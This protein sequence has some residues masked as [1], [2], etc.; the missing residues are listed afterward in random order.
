M[1][2]LF[3]STLFLLGASLPALQAQDL[4]AQQIAFFKAFEDAT[5]RSDVDALNALYSD[6]VTFLNGQDGS[7]SLKMNRQQLREADV[8]QFSEIDDRMTMVIETVEA[9]ADGKVKTGGTFSG[10]N[11]NKKTGLQNNYSAVFEA[12]T[13]MENGQW[14]LLQIKTWHP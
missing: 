5:N 8:K 6:E 14:R 12:I 2:H 11:T 3:F 4:K 9:L 1:K 10:V 7:R 13:A